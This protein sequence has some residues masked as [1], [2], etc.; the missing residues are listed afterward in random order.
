MTTN[1][2]ILSRMADDLQRAG[3]YSVNISLDTL[4]ASKFEK[5][6]RRRGFDRVI[7]AIDDALERFE[8]VK[9]NCVLMRGV[10]EEELLSFVDFTKDKPIYVRFIEWMPFDKNQWNNQKFI[11]YDEALQLIRAEHGEKIEKAADEEHDTSKA[12]RINGYA[13]KF[14]FI[15]SMSQNFCSTCNRLR[16]TADGNIKVRASSSS[17]V[18][19]QC[20]QLICIAEKV[21]L[22]GNEEVSLRDALR[23]GFTE[24]EIGTVIK[25][26]VMEKKFMLGGHKDMNAL[27]RSPNR[28]MILIGG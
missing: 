19:Y 26:S 22:F 1:G 13:G 18:R 27:A 8:E 21:C 9:L 5:I 6:T 12:Y 16:L 15:T 3:L 10:N 11:A 14:G 17:S 23:G 28:P 25:A 2:I 7:R 20:S 4:Q 24:E